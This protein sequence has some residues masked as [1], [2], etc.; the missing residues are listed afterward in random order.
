MYDLRRYI[1]EYRSQF[2][3]N[4]VNK[5]YKKVLLL[6]V[7]IITVHCKLQLIEYD[8][9][10]SISSCTLEAAIQSFGVV[11]NINMFSINSSRDNDLLSMLYHT[12]YLSKKLKNFATFKVDF[13]ETFRSYT[14]IAAFDLDEIVLNSKQIHKLLLWNSRSWYIFVIRKNSIASLDNTVDLLWFNYIYNA[15]ILM[16]SEQNADVIEIY[17]WFPF[18]NGLCGKNFKARIVNRCQ[19]GIFENNVTLFPPKVPH[20]FN[21]CPIRA[22]VI[23]TPPY[24]MPPDDGILLDD[25]VLNITDGL[26][27]LL[28]RTIAKFLNLTFLPMSSTIANDWGLATADGNTSGT[29]RILY[30]KKAELGFGSYGPTAERRMYCDY[31]ASHTYESLS[32]CVP[33]AQLA[34][35]WRNLLD[36]FQYSTWLS[37][38]GAYLIVSSI[39]W[40][41]CYT[42]P[43]D[44]TSY[45]MLKN[46]FKNLFS[47]FIAISAAETPKKGAGRIVFFVWIVFGLHFV[48]A[49]QAKLISVL[50]HPSY[51]KQMNTLDEILNSEM[52]WASLPTLKRFFNN[53]DDWRVY[54]IIEEWKT[55]QNALEGLRRIAYERDF[56][57]CVLEHNARYEILK[58]LGPDLQP[59][60]YCM[61]SYLTYPSEIYMTKGFP[62]R[63]HLDK[64]IYRIK[65]TGLLV[66]WKNDISYTVKITNR[67]NTGDDKSQKLT[68]SHLQGAFMVL[69]L[70][71]G[72]SVL[73]IICEIIYIIVR[74]KKMRKKMFY[75]WKDYVRHSVNTRKNVQ[76]I[77]VF[78]NEFLLDR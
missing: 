77:Q 65:A 28:M 50:L 73:A 34:P 54:K 69:G 72:F 19:Y 26:E 47:I 22:Q 25:K 1:M 71:L 51:E 75:R 52:D 6:Q 44:T 38:I 7:I 5:M 46:C 9:Y 57:F 17:S 49:Y 68:L 45:V 53:T 55:H 23:I 16:P 67:K 31:S 33:K 43:K 78:G 60:V 37:I 62:L 58:L 13:Y 39:T 32:W 64:L 40:I 41:F 8:K 56:A 30:E 61:P 63:D 36:T 21:G 14:V 24:V 2:Y 35:R 15:V 11:P 42:T 4:T 3:L 59:L 29:I 48:A 18:E 27:I 70:G 12:P 20:I 10:E 74:Y 76:I 66:K